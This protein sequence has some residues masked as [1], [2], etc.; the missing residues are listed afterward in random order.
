MNGSS[1][2]PELVVENIDLSFR[3]LDDM[4]R[5]LDER[6]QFLNSGSTPDRAERIVIDG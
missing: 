2:D 3:V 5:F 1:L 6:S 4:E